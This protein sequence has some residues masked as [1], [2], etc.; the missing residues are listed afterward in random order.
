MDLKTMTLEQLREI[1]KIKALNE[2]VGTVDAQGAKRIAV[3]IKRNPE[4]FKSSIGQKYIRTLTAILKTGECQ[5]LICDK[6]AAAGDVFCSEHAALDYEE[7]ARQKQQENL[8]DVDDL[9]SVLLESSSEEVSENSPALTKMVD[10]DFV[11]ESYRKLSDKITNMTGE[12]DGI[13]FKFRDLF[14][15]VFKHHSSEEAEKIFIAGTSLTTPETKDISSEWPKP[16]LYSRVLL[17]ILATYT[18]LWLFVGQWGNL[19]GYPGLMFIGALSVPFSVVIFFWEINI[20]RN[21]SLIEVVKVF[22]IGGVLSLIYTLTLSD[23]LGSK[24]IMG[25]ADAMLV[26]LVEETAKALALIL[27]LRKAKFKYILNGLLLGAAV[28]AGFA[29]FE[30][31]GYAFETFIFSSWSRGLTNVVN[32]LTVRSILAIGGHVA[33]TA[34]VGA[35]IMVVKKNQNLERQ[36][37]FDPRFIKFL[38]IAILLH[39]LWDCYA[40]FDFPELFGLNSF[41]IILTAII[42]IILLIVMSAGLRQA[43]RMANEAMKLEESS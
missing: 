22:L 6:K 4:Q 17:Y 2:K 40:F 26:G 43:T 11:K 18:A 38:L 23:L 34:F 28:G 36:H 14:S 35:G 10:N 33:W 9:E 37:I 25:Y 16:W 39:G 5:C 30:T 20:P 7:L 31:A 24:A 1:K 12:K 19:K 27:F 21:V 42:W 13:K 29:V 32:N 8:L 3:V 41:L 15:A